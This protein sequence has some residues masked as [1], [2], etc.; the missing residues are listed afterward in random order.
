MGAADEK[1][2]RL[3]WKHQ[4]TGLELPPRS[5]KRRSRPVPNETA[6]QEWLAAERGYAS[7]VGRAPPR[8]SNSGS[9][10]RVGVRD[11]FTSGAKRS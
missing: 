6:E 4:Q 2:R 9:R 11:S 8:M 1:S 3:L 5:T 10:Q 7:H